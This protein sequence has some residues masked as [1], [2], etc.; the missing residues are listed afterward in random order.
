M[1]GVDDLQHLF[2]TS[3]DAEVVGE[4]DPAYHPGSIDKEFRGTRNICVIR[5]GAGVKQIVPPDYFGLGIG[6]KGVGKTSLAAKFAA[7][8]RRIDADRRHTDTALFKFTK[9][10]LDSPQ[11]GD[12]EGS[13]IAAIKN[14][15]HAF[16]RCCRC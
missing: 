15:Q 1:L 4:I 9:V 3:A 2:R 7:Y 16:R 6:E 12:A 14:Q 11:L 13:P 10:F 8:L 5:A